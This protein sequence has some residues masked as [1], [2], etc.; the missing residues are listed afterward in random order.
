MIPFHLLY[1]S[2]YHS[3]FVD[4][5]IWSEKMH[6]VTRP[7]TGLL[8]VQPHSF[9]C[10]TDF[11]LWGIASPPLTLGCWVNSPSRVPT[12]TPLGSS[13]I[14]WYLL[15]KPNILPAQKGFFNE[16]SIS[17]SDSFTHW[18]GPSNSSLSP[19]HQWSALLLSAPFT[20]STIK[21]GVNS[22]CREPWRSAHPTTIPLATFKTF[23]IKRLASAV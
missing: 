3:H 23:I 11:W 1:H 12:S 4:E 13:R 2:F 16:T 5:N 21:N 20:P 18:M 22:I 17:W 9:D 8:D 14:Q 10:F 7:I 15:G 6:M 19:R